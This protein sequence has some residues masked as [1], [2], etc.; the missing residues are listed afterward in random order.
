M[1]DEALKSGDGED[2]SLPDFRGLMMVFC[3]FPDCEKARSAGRTIVASG[4][5]ACVNL[6]PSVESIYSWEGEIQQDNEILA[7]FKVREDGYDRLEKALLA[8]HP[9]D[10][11]EIIGIPAGKVE[12]AYLT[13][14]RESALLD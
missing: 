8:I 2:S 13:W 11:P 9:Y 10:T 7:I 1:S 14:V 12:K 5:A 6:I 4:H 3:T